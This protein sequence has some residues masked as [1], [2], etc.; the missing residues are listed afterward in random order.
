MNRLSKIMLATALTLGAGQAT[1]AADLLSIYR[2]AQVQDSTYAGAKAQYIGAQEKLPQ[3]RALLRPSVNFSA[4]THYNDV[5]SRYTTS[6]F[7]S[8]R[9]DYYDYNYG[10]NVT[11]PLYRRQ[12]SATFE[13]AKVQ[14]RQADT[15]L[16]AASQDL[17][18]RVAQGYFDVLLARANL[19]STPSRSLSPPAPPSTPTA[20]TSTPARPPSR[21]L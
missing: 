15:Q 9:T 21:A 3:A 12:N 14:V 20:C 8:G 2:E 19:R 18:T 11:Q 17:M 10:V 1:F 16:T 7:P 4:G 6:A 5:D 13:Q